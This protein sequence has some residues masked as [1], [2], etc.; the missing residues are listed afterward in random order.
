ME[1]HTTN[2]RG[3]FFFSFSK[4]DKNIN[5]C[6]VPVFHQKY[7]SWLNLNM[8]IHSTSRVYNISE[9]LKPQLDESE[10]TCN[11]L[12][13]P[14]FL[15]VFF[16]FLSCSS[17]FGTHSVHKLIIVTKSG[18]SNLHVNIQITHKKNVQRTPVHVHYPLMVVTTWQPDKLFFNRTHW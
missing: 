9:S 3:N 1:R 14:G 2:I 10:S 11:S 7:L 17:I 18:F 4:W 13:V 8:C 16:V 5:K 6:P 15:F 12:W